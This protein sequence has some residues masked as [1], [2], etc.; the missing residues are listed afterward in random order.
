MTRTG[1]PDGVASAW[2][3]DGRK[4]A[5][6]AGRTMGSMIT[7]AFIAILDVT[8]SAADRP[9]AIAQLARERP[10]VRSMP[11]CLD[12]RVFASSETD[13]GITVLHEWTDPASFADY[14]GS[15]AFARSGRL[16]RPMMTEPAS[17]RRFRVELIE[18]VV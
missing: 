15:D 17:S 9:A 10:I 18:T 12:F 14:L 16:L 8:T 11:G 13:G 5:R 4:R 1:G 6:A 3:S 7:P 2:S